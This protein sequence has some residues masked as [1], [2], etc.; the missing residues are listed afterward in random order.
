VATQVLS[1]V[2]LGSMPCFLG[3]KNRLRMNGISSSWGEVPS[4]LNEIPE[5]VE[6]KS[7]IPRMGRNRGED[8]DN[9]VES[10][11]GDRPLGHLGPP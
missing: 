10:P 7:E 8:D 1:Q 9:E 6:D 11:L 5:G 3:C 4:P 2:F